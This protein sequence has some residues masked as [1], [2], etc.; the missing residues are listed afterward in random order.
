MKRVDGLRTSSSSPR[1]NPRQIA[2][3]AALV[4]L[5][6]GDGVAT[7]DVSIPDREE[8]KWQ[9]EVPLTPQVS[10][11]PP[12]ELFNRHHL[13]AFPTIAPSQRAHQSIHLI[14]CCD[15]GS[16]ALY[17]AGLREHVT[18][19]DWKVEWLEETVFD[20]LATNPPTHRPT[21]RP[22]DPSTH[23]HTNPPTI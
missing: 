18:Q 20:L 4:P 16:R 6:V 7:I 23:Q 15:E 1:V 11:D 8:P 19:V 3:N 12:N 9:G 17:Y 13:V 5:T 2:R 22:T 14:E 10:F 21:D